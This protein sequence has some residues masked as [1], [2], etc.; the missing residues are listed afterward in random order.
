MR[1]SFKRGLVSVWFEIT[2]PIFKLKLQKNL[3]LIGVGGGRFKLNYENIEKPY[4]VGSHGEGFENV[5]ENVFVLQ[6]ENNLV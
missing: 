3:I 5:P 2:D 1:F 4:T 6:L